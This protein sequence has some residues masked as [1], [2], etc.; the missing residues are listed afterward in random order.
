[1]DTQGRRIKK[2]RLA[3]GLSQK[4]LSDMVGIVP[5]HLQAYEYGTRHPK[6]EILNRLAKALDVTPSMLQPLDVD[7]VN[8]L[9]GIIYEMH[10]SYHGL[11]IVEEDGQISIRLPNTL[12][13]M[14]AKKSL[15]RIKKILDD[16]TYQPY[17]EY[18]SAKDIQE[19]NQ[20]LPDTGVTVAQE[21]RWVKEQEGLLL[22][23]TDLYSP[24]VNYNQIEADRKALRKQYPDDSDYSLIK[25]GAYGEE[26]LYTVCDVDTRKYHA[27]RER[28]DYRQF[29][30]DKDK[31]Y[32]Q[33][34]SNLMAL[35]CNFSA[36]SFIEDKEK[37]PY[38]WNHVTD[39]LLR[40]CEP[41]VK[42]K[43]LKDVKKEK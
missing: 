42:S 26:Y 8:G 34:L 31:Y 7:T 10:T 3:K 28:P 36:D 17:P 1:M 38:M 21:K 2:L 40:E 35:R 12:Q 14:P 33:M 25:F 43:I 30:A 16:Y 32:R 5:T 41:I 37:R 23:A 29:I 19:E 6:E 20:I 15:L 13:A 22:R 39:R 18:Q 24:D 27:L 9:L 4:R 11:E